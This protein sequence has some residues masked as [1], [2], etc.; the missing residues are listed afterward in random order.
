PAEVVD[1]G[2]RGDPG[3]GLACP[4]T[5]GGQDRAQ[6]VA[7]PDVEMLLETVARGGAGRARRCRGLRGRPGP[8]RGA[9]APSPRVPGRREPE[10]CASPHWTWATRGS[11][12]R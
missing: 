12:S 6:G 2:R 5:A 7:A 3:P 4:Q 9:S 8:R 1:A 11:V 10:G